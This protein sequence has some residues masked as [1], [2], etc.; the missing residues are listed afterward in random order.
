MKGLTIADATKLLLVLLITGLFGALILVHAPG[1]NGPGYWQWP[2]RRL[3]ATRL[4][5]AMLA[6]ALPF[7][8]G[9]HLYQRRRRWPLALALVML[10]T[11]CLELVALGMQSDPFGLDRIASNVADPL[12]TSYYTDAGSFTS[13]GAWLSAFP[14][15]LPSFH[16]HSLNKPPGPILFYVAFIHAFGER[17]AFVGGLVLGLLAT[18]S[19]LATFGLVRVLGES[20][21]AGFHAASFMALTPSLVLFYP[22][23]DQ[24]YPVLTSALIATWVCALERNRIAWSLSFGFALAVALF[25]TYS[26]LVLGIFL[27]AYTVFHLV[28]SSGRSAP[29]VLKHTGAGLA[30]LVGTYGALWVATGFDPVAAFRTSLQNQD[31]LLEL[32]PRPYPETILFDLTDFILGATWLSVLLVVL[33]GIE[34]VGTGSRSRASAGHGARRRDGGVDGRRPAS[35]VKKL[36]K[37]EKRRRRRKRQKAHATARKAASRTP[38][39][40][41]VLTNV[42]ISVFQILVVAVT[43]LLPGETARVWI[44]LLPLLL[45]PVGLEL[46]EWKAGPRLAVYGCLVLLTTLVSQNMWFIR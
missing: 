11:F 35:P 40:P 34:S 46:S 6:A 26:L 12:I 27:G 39:H 45:L 17:A 7:F 22:E 28:R 41:R 10:S 32:I 31:R 15:L 5:P 1:L 21:S 24:V 29:A 2:W 19:V 14:E 38:V 43:G 25:F 18:G 20:E 3:E 36:T 42:G 13:L 4:Y 44:F 16:L 33:F 30:V 8:L 37:K 23:F 9:Q